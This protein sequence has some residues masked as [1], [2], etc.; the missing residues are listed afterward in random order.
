MCDPTD[1]IGVCEEAGDGEHMC[2]CDDYKGSLPCPY[3]TE[4][5]AAS[6]KI[7]DGILL[8]TK[9]N[10]R[11]VQYIAPGRRGSYGAEA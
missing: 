1:R 11:K 10:Y 6:I 3:C 4:R 2:L 8:G 5:C 9:P 7:C